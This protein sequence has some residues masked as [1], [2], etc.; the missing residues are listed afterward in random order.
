MFSKTSISNFGPFTDLTWDN[1]D[2]INLLIGAN[3][4]GKTYLLKILYCLAKSLEEFTKRQRSDKAPWKEILAEKL[5]WTFQ[6]GDRGLGE[7]VNKSRDGRLR[8]SANLL[9]QSYYFAFG[10]DTTRKILDCTDVK[11]PVENLNTL[12]L[13]PKEVLTALD[14]IAATREQLHIFGFDDTYQDLITALRLP[15][16]RTSL[17]DNF[18]DGLQ[19]L[20]RIFDGEVIKEGKEFLFRCGRERYGMS[21]TAEGIKKIGILSLLIKNGNLNK[22]TIL[23][24]DEPETNLHPYAVF[25]LVNVLFQLSKMG[26]HIFLATH[27][28]YVIKQF[29]ILARRN[30]Q[31]IQLSSL[32]RENKVI[33]LQSASLLDGMPE[34][35]LIDASIHQYEEEVRLDMES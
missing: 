2:R 9:D 16:K 12:F 29:E 3:D 34:N 26:V 27:S 15:P 28:Y 31:S 25:E 8:V 10:K 11:E 7:L 5:Y 23:F 22:A 13:P 33:S 4:T 21:Q 24:I 35:L 32:I 20:E 17:S 6:V 14:A 30:Q 1:R 18:L 19:R